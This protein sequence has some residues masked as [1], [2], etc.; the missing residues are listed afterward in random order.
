MQ[1]RQ[2]A[3]RCRKEALDAV[4]LLFTPSR[5]YQR[6]FLCSLPSR[7]TAETA[8]K[9]RRVSL[10]VHPGK[11]W[12]VGSATTY[13]R[14][15]CLFPYTSGRL[16]SSAGEIATYQATLGAD[17]LQLSSLH[18]VYHKYRILEFYK[19]VVC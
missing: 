5:H 7:H 16:F 8:E 6:F 18:S 12:Q 10:P 14:A 17:F 15:M 13:G 19:K 11:V 3:K 4:R 2:F 1:V 9:Y